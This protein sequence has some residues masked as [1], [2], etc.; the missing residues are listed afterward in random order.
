MEKSFY[1]SD[2]W[3]I[4]TDPDNKGKEE[5]FAEKIQEQV[6]DARV[7]GVIQ[8]A[9]TSY[10]G[11]VWYY[12]TIDKVPEISENEQILLKF[13]SVDYYCDVYLDGE[14]LGSHEG[15]QAPFNFVVTKKVQVGSLLA[16]RVINPREDVAIDGLLL[17]ETPH[18]CKGGGEFPIGGLYNFGGITEPVSLCV[19]PKVYISDIFAHGNIHTG[20]AEFEITVFSFDDDPMTCELDLS[21]CHTT[22]R[23]PCATEKEKITVLS[24]ENIY[25]VA[26]NIENPLLWS[27]DTP[28]L[29]KLTARVTTIDTP[30]SVFCV[31]F[32]YR[33]FKIEKGFFFLNGKRVYLKSTHTTSLY[34]ITIGLPPPGLQ[35]LEYR[36]FQILKAAGFNCVRFIAFQPSPRQLDYCDSLGLMVYSENF[37]SWYL[38]N[39]PRAKEH[40]YRTTLAAV[41]RDRSHPS[42]IIWGMLNET[43]G[44]DAH[45]SAVSIL[46]ELRKLDNTRLV[47]LS[48]GKFVRDF[49]LGCAANPGS[50]EWECV[51]GDDGNTEGDDAK[52]EIGDYHTYPR[53]PH[54]EEAEFNLIRNYGK[55]KKPVFLSEYGIC[56][57][58]DVISVCR[59]Y[60]RYGAD[61]TAPD[62]RLID[63]IR[64]K[65]EAAFE[66]YGLDKVYAHPVDFLHDSERYNAKS[67]R[68]QF[69]MLRSNPRFCGY[70]LTGCLDQA[71]SGEGPITLFRQVKK[72]HF[73]A[74]SD[75]WADL[76]WSLFI[77]KGH[78]YSGEEQTFE[79][80]LSNIDVLA[81]GEYN[82]TFAV[83][84]EN[85]M[86]YWKKKCSFTLP[87]YD[88]EGLNLL[89]FPV[90]N[91]TVKLTLKPGKYK[92]C[93]YLENGGAPAAYEKE[94]F[95]SEKP[96]DMLN[97][98][99]GAIGLTQE[100]VDFLK[101][102]GV[103]V[104][105]ELEKCDTIIVGSLYSETII[106]DS[107][108]P[109][110]YWP[111]LDHHEPRSEATRKNGARVMELCK[112]G[113]RVLFLESFFLHNH[114]DGAPT[115]YLDFLG[116]K[117]LS[118]FLSP[119]WFYHKDTAV[120]PH[121]YT[122]GVKKGFLDWSYYYNC[123][124]ID[125]IVTEENA[126]CASAFFYVAGPIWCAPYSEM[127]AGHVLSEFKFGEGSFVMTAFPLLQNTGNSPAGDR[128]LLNLL[129]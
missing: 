106:G 20:D 40:F 83:A 78:M 100:S 9:Y 58:M 47:L 57:V 97:K 94:F 82:V 6:K 105:D 86:P 51:W 61:M 70:N 4:I 37:A 91:E 120:M 14:L 117:D 18:S 62:C 123:I 52:K 23:I 21:V 99:V 110:A 129:K 11:V 16:V 122:Y 71:V 73:D 3:K 48:S 31:N 89:A 103:T 121:K 27:F 63:R 108:K 92:L 87:M 29:Y 79:A 102:H 69:D 41:K 72:E 28:D 7:P 5:K 75:G 32:G 33:E 93:A 114:K 111:T 119:D 67:R 98:T 30:D 124:P 118:C 127:L 116:I 17:P 22:E 76:R 112:K 90:M 109:L 95:V 104:T 101:E 49:S 59:N 96:T 38:N 8:Q 80:V 19:V 64:R 13:E 44:G 54:N 81:D 128:I 65:Y 56:S 36:D 126:D 85:G 24:G 66:K 43:F 42:L 50:S 115:N 107:A 34:P 15:A 125:A 60:E 113:K 39:S 12:K 53:Y 25:K 46:P 84:D 45:D 2:G 74:L 10:N 68:D 35:Q 55:G 1:L 26:V 77:R 88:T